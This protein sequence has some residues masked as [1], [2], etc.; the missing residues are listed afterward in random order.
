M[1]FLFAFFLSEAIMTGCCDDDLVQARVVSAAVV[2]DESPADREPLPA[3]AP[4]CQCAHTT[5]VFRTAPPRTVIALDQRV[6]TY[7]VTLPPPPS[8]TL[9]PDIRPPIN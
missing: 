5:S 7:T 9:Q 6:P 2:S 3:S 8:R 1:S 4:V